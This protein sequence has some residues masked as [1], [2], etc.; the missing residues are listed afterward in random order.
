MKILIADDHGLYREGLKS[1]VNRLI[2]QAEILEATNSV[3]V[4]NQVEAHQDLALLLLDFYLADGGGLN[5]IKQLRNDYPLVP[6]AVLSGVEDPNIIR[7]VLAEG[8]NGFLT[9]SSSNTVLE[10]ALKLVLAGGVF[11]PE[12]ITCQQITN[13]G[14]TPSNDQL[15][16]RQ[17]Q[18]LTLLSKGMSNKEIGTSLNLAEGTVKAHVAALLKSLGARN[19]TEA[20][21]KARELGTV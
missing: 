18:V 10:H 4:I 2:P 13:S 3:E 5:L 17:Q 16:P 19:R 7:L 12:Q 1:T 6:I 21:N 8:V 14:Y 15:T 11:I 20:A 9:K